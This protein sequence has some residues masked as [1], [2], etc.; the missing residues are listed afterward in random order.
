ML[1]LGN[2]ASGWFRDGGRLGGSSSLYMSFLRGFRE[3]GRSGF[4]GA[5][6]S[7]SVDR[8]AAGCTAEA[9]EDSGGAGDLRFTGLTGGRWFVV[10]TG[11]DAHKSE[12]VGIR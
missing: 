3:A 10:L 2:A 1:V 11:G 12:D 5:E 4:T 8:V 9:A 7:G 6:S